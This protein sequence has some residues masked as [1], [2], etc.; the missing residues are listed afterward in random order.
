MTK[1]QRKIL[2]TIAEKGRVC[3]ALG[4]GHGAEGG[5]V[6]YGSREWDAAVR[7]IEAG[8]VQR[9]GEIVHASYTRRGY[10]VHVAEMLLI[11]A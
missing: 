6:S 9:S 5:K 11:A 7:L 2:D 8:K 4:G 10:T 3:V 1:T